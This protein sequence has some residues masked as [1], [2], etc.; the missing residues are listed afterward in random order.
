[1]DMLTDTLN[2]FRVIV[3]QPD[4]VYLSRF[5]QTKSKVGKRW[6]KVRR[7]TGWEDRIEDG[8]TLVDEANRML[9]M[10]EATRH[11]FKRAGI[12]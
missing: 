9:Y 6:V 12:A 3:V 11:E 5:R 2:G 4:P 10:N 7:F 1:M 8:Q